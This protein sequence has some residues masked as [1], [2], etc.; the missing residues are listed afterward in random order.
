MKVSTDACLFG[1]W[2]AQHFETTQ[3]ESILDIGT[4]TGLLTLML[5]QKLSGKIATIEI[6]QGAHLQATDN[7]LKTYW[8]ERIEIIHADATKHKF[9]NQFD[10]IISNPPFYQHDL[11][12]PEKVLNMARHDE[13]LTLESLL[14]IV[15]ACLSTAGFFAVLVPYHRADYLLNAAAYFNLHPAFIT[16]VR[17]SANHNYFRSMIILKENY[18]AGIDAKEL[19]IKD[20]NNYTPDF[21]ALL[22]DYYLN[23]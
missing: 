22:K 16:H 9:K 11:R 17:Q 20:A 8:Q 18:N 15:S 12:S 21:I 7:I 2:V 1:G 6:D 23:L 4:G 14:S 13:T 5:A 19:I 3:P 10:L